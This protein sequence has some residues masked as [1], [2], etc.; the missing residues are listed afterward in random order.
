MYIIPENCEYFILI[1]YSIP[2]R[3]SIF[4]KNPISF[5][6]FISAVFS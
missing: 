3:Y 4:K 5:F 6:P 1:R 2:Y